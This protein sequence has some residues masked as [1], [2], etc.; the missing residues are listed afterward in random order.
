MNPG[1]ENGFNADA[2]DWTEIAGPS[3]T[4]VR[5]PNA[6]FNGGWSAYMAFDHITLINMTSSGP[7][8]ANL[9]LDGILD[10]SGQIPLHEPGRC[11]QASICGTAE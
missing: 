2:Q 11:Y 7:E 10:K 5:S 1:F 6:P 4:V 3:G 8:I 9:R